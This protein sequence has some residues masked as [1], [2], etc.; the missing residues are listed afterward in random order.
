M[1]QYTFSLTNFHIKIPNVRT[2]WIV[3]LFY[4]RDVTVQILYPI[5]SILAE[6]FRGFRQSIQTN[7]VIS[8]LD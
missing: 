6:V 4:I 5:P 7:P 1:S 3:I 2:E 8:T